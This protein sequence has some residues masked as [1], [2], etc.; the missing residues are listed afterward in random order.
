MVTTRHATQIHPKHR[1][2]LLAFRVGRSSQQVT[3]ASPEREHLSPASR[4]HPSRYGTG[5]TRTR[6]SQTPTGHPHP[7]VVACHHP[8]PLPTAH[9]HACCS[10]FFPPA[11]T[12]AP[13]LNGARGHAGRT[14]PRRCNQWEEQ[15]PAF[16]REAAAAWLGIGARGVGLGHRVGHWL[17]LAHLANHLRNFMG[18]GRKGGACTFGRLE[19]PRLT[20]GQ[21]AHGGL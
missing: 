3:Q 15:L 21:H 20:P 14:G 11:G 18:S 10:P 6:P 16:Q 8:G 19:I 12:A 13:S 2:C 4:S 7:D 1:R 5:A 17:R 9:R